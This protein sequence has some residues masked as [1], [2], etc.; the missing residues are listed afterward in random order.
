VVHWPNKSHEE[1]FVRGNIFTF[2]CEF[3]SCVCMLTKLGLLACSLHRERVLDQTGGLYVC[4]VF[5]GRFVVEYK[6]A[7]YMYI[8]A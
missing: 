2:F 6:D 4:L 8:N 5:E 1:V 7:L 3:I